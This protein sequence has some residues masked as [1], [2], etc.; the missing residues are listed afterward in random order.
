MSF[1]V[2][3]LVL[4]KKP[5]TRNPGGVVM[6]SIDF[7]EVGRNSGEMLTLR[8]FC[9]R[10][11][12]R[13]R[14]SRKS[15]D[16]DQSR[17]SSYLQPSP[18]WV[19][20]LQQIQPAHIAG[21]VEALTASGLSPATVRRFY[22][23]V[24]V[25]FKDAAVRGHVSQS[26]CILGAEHLPKKALPSGRQ[27]IISFSDF[28]RLL[29]VVTPQRKAIYS[30]LFLTGARV[31]EVAGLNWADWDKSRQPLGALSVL[32]QFH[33]GRARI[34]EG[35][36]TGVLK[37]LPVHR[38][39]ASALSSWRL[40]YQKTT[41]FFPRGESPIFVTAIKR[42]HWR[43]D[44]LRNQFKRDLKKAG[45]RVSHTPH[46]FRHSF[47]THALAGGA[48]SRTVRKITHPN[49]RDILDQYTHQSWGDFCRVV[50]SIK[51]R[52][53]VKAL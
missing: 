38:F 28:F 40:Q 13:R 22:S 46:D 50:N 48:D 43:A 31:G 4:T 36:K 44:S 11:L 29:E 51:L 30:A 12:S 5:G 24:S 15:W 21:M 2:I 20:Q 1:A 3:A 8:D 37:V 19:M 41:G 23:L 33:T 53:Q 47:I 35:T 39:L 17:I 26:P 45:L 25:I 52:G 18:L 6:R 34:E 14:V 7:S 16:T 10:W 49:P 27:K 32:R 42:Q 9:T